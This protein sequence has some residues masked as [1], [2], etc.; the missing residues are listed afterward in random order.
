MVY[1]KQFTWTGQLHMAWYSKFM[2]DSLFLAAAG[3]LRTSVLLCSIN[4]QQPLANGYL[5]HEAGEFKAVLTVYV[6]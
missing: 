3:Y 2:I 4:A 6:L 1:K 5:S